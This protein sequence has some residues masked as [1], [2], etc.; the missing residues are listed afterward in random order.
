MRTKLGFSKSD[1]ARADAGKTEPSQGRNAPTISGHAAFAPPDPASAGPARAHLAGGIDSGGSYAARVVTP[2]GHTAAGNPRTGLVPSGKSG[3][4]ALAGFWGRRDSQG[5]LVPLTDPALAP[6][7]P[8]MRRAR[9]RRRVLRNLAI[10][11]GSAVAS[12]AA[13]LALL[14]W[15]DHAERAA[16]A[17]PPPVVVPAPTAPN[18]PTPVRTIDEPIPS[19][20]GASP[21]VNRRSPRRAPA[22][23]KPAD[24]DQLLR[25]SPL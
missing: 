20:Q 2:A 9:P 4:P 7:M 8:R 14:A 6:P 25:P 16:G 24:D 15:R 11:A 12:F 3:F 1:L 23:T 18:E 17:P 13:V 5:D 10:L 22:P 19:R 21:T